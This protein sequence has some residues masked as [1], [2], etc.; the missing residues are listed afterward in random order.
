M[1][2]IRVRKVI[3]KNGRVRYRYR[4][5]S[6]DWTIKEVQDE[7]RFKFEYGET[8][9]EEDIRVLENKWKYHLKSLDEIYEENTND[10]S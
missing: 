7:A 10:K 4:A 6:Y 3:E 9:T 1:K 8:I 2:T 5:G